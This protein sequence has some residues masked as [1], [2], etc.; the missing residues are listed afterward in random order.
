MLVK[1]GDSKISTKMELKLIED[2]RAKA[3][4]LKISK[5]KAGKDLRLKTFI[6]ISD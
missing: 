5:K 2:F 6:S 4:Y 3:S 1:M